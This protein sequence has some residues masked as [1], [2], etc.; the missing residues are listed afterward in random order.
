MNSS[1]GDIWSFA[2]EESQ[3]QSNQI[4]GPV[5]LFWMLTFALNVIGQSC[6]DVLGLD[7]GHRWVLQLSPIIY[8]MDSVDVALSYLAL[9]VVRR[10]RISLAV[11]RI[12]RDSIKDD[13][14][15]KKLKSHTALRWMA[16]AIGVLPQIIKVSG[17]TGVLVS[18][19][20]CV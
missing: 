19:T 17:S 9:V 3:T 6:G 13:H 14:G 12:L 16:F 8:T 1:V 18:I 15:I 5:V 10:E 11:T 20:K 7:N 2:Q 4:Q